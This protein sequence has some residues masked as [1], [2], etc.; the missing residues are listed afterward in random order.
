LV[1]DTF[2]IGRNAAVLKRP[3]R[4]FELVGVEAKGDQATTLK[5][6][7]HGHV[8]ALVG[9]LIDPQADDRLE[10]GIVHRVRPSRTLT[11]MWLPLYAQQRGSRQSVMTV[12]DSKAVHGCDQHPATGTS[13]RYLSRMPSRAVIRVTQAGWPPLFTQRY[14]R[15]WPGL[16]V[17]PDASDGGTANT[18]VAAATAM[19]HRRIMRSPRQGGFI[20]AR[21]CRRRH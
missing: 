13:G 10:A 12:Q 9:L 16:S 18:A 15:V 17:N 21:S 8:A 1:G 4:L 19:M 20:A 5:R 14:E 11:L 6:R 2:V 3:R 7:R